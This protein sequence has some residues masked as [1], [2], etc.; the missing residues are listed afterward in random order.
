MPLGGRLAY[1]NEQSPVTLGPGEGNDL[2][3][4]DADGDLSDD[5][6]QHEADGVEDPF[7]GMD[8]EALLA[9]VSN[10]GPQ[11]FGAEEPPMDPDAPIALEGEEGFPVDPATTGGDQ[12]DLLA[13]Q[14]LQGFNG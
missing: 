14:L 11:G 6:M 8:L 13:Q 2:P 12:M 4:Q 1:L 10:G 5:P 7:E 9:G 3:Y